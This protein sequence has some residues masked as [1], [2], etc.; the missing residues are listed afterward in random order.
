VSNGT[1]SLA[2]LSRHS[3]QEF[4]SVQSAAKLTK[5]PHALRQQSNIGFSDSNGAFSSDNG[6]G[7]VFCAGGSSA[8][9]ASSKSALQFSFI[10]SINASAASSAA[11]LNDNGSAS[12]TRWKFDPLTAAPFPVT[13]VLSHS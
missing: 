12:D 7:T 10:S 2:I 1:R 9:S 13:K 8:A 5:Q 4:V 11:V 6:K 3:L